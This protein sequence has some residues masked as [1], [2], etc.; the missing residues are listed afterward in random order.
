MNYVRE[1]AHRIFAGELNNSSLQ[2]EKSEKHSPKYIIT[3]TGTKCK[4]IFFVGT[5][6]EKTKIDS[7]S[8]VWSARISDPTGIFYIYVGHNQPESAK[9]L[10]KTA[11]LEF[12]A[13]IGNTSTY[14]TKTGNVITSVWAESVQVVDETTRDKWVADTVKH[15]ILSLINLQGNGPNSIR[16]KNH[17]SIDILDDIITMVKSALGTIK[18]NNK[19]IIHKIER[20]RLAILPPNNNVTDFIESNAD[21]EFFYETDKIY[22]QNELN[23][24]NEYYYQLFLDVDDIKWEQYHK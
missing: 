19:S 24:M 15:T 20:I 21:E 9:I 13:V 23:Q 5:L 7:S 18:I 17:Y 16:V 10:A 4:R 11:L 12:V 14:T 8:L 2:E 22:N 6:I 3:P 1:V